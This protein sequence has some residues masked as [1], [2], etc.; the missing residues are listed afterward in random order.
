MTNNR[1]FGLLALLACAASAVLTAP[2]DAATPA[3][4]PCAGLV[5]GDPLALMEALAAPP[6]L[7]DESVLFLGVVASAGLT[8]EAE[9]RAISGS[10]RFP[11]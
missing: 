1:R 11:G 8:V 10:A 6:Q 3:C 2:L 5:T 7:N 4:R 9:L